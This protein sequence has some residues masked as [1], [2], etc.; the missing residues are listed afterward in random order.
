MNPGNPV[1]VGVV[2][3][4]VAGVGDMIAAPGVIGGNSGAD[5]VGATGGAVYVGY[6]GGGGATGATGSVTVTTGVV[7]VG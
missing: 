7:A 2:G 1:F 6:G 4:I 3:I 5:S